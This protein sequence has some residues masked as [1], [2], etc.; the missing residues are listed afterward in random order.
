MELKEY[1]E[2]CHQTAKAK[3]F[4]DKERE[5]GTILMLIVSELG[6]ALEADRHTKYAVSAWDPNTCSDENFVEQF[7]KNYKD[8]VTDE[9]ADTFIR[10]FDLCGGLEIDIEKHIQAKMRYNETRARLHGKQY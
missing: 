8:C 3:G 10:L 1:V 9:L 4:W 2:K 6:E 7:E 5:F